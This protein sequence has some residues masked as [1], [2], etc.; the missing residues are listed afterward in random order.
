M[1]ENTNMDTVDQFRAAISWGINNLWR[2]TQKEFASMLGI[3][4]RYLSGLKK[5]PN[6][7][8]RTL[9]E[10]IAKELGFSYLDFLALGRMLLDGVPEEE[11]ERKASVLR[12]RP[13]THRVEQSF[14]LSGGNHTV[15]EGDEELFLTSDERRLLGTYRKLNDKNKYHALITLMEMEVMQFKNS[16]KEDDT[17]PAR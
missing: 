7:G 8:S 15:Q 1:L 4:E 13:D 17:P 12:K 5:G 9:Q 2:G 11:V 3:S 6:T 16:S 14:N 10:R